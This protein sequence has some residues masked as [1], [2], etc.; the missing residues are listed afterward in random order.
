T[1]LLR[2]EG[3]LPDGRRYLLRP[4]RDGDHLALFALREAVAA[5]G[6]LIAAMPGD[7]TAA[8]AELAVVALRADGGLS[9]VAEVDA[10]P[11]AHLMVR[12]RPGVY[13]RHVAEL[14][15]IVDNGVRGGGIGTALIELAA[16][17]CRAVGVDKLEL[18]VFTGN[19]RAIS[20]YHR[21]GFVD[22]GLRRDAVRVGGVSH[23]LR[24]MARSLHA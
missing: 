4:S 22:E 24:L 11:V 16:D 17:W 1:A 3:V 15:I 10:A 2:R 6:G 7:T 8:E 18:C 9:V 23:D 14:A 13:E 21:C 5:E 19:T 20:L 12:R